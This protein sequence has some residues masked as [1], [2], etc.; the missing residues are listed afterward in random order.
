MRMTMCLW[1]AGVA[2]GCQSK[3]PDD[4]AGVTVVDTGPATPVEHPPVPGWPPGR[5]AGPQR[6][7]VQQLRE[8]VATA[9]GNDVNGAPIAWMIGNSEGL[10]SLGE[11][12]GAPDYLDTTEEGR[13]INALY[14]KF[15]D[16][17]ARDVCRKALDHDA[18]KAT[19]AE[20]TLLRHVE[21]TDTAT[22]AGFDQ[23]LRYLKLRFHGLRVAE[24]DAAATASL[25][26]LFSQVISNATAGGPAHA[27]HIRQAWNAVCIALVTA[28]EFHIY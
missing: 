12:L 13:E 25:R 23:N 9:L 4:R 10:V 27:S 16:D 15:M 18:A 19:G 24:S 14:L 26:R 5:P 3:D 11:V 21:W 6:L 7:T 17:L 22:T 8:S 2:L 28:P 1:I 20:R